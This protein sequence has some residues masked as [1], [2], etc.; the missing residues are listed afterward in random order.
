MY[1]IS[2]MSRWSFRIGAGVAAFWYILLDFRSGKGV[3]K[4]RFLAYIVGVFRSARVYPLSG[5]SC[6]SLEMANVEFSELVQ[7]DTCTLATSGPQWTPS[8]PM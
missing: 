3:S 6:S 5:I 8:L 4:F 1:T 2:G 7:K